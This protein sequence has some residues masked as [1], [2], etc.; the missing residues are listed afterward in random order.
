MLVQRACCCTAVIER[1]GGGEGG[2]V[3]IGDACAR[4]CAFSYKRAR[5]CACVFVLVYARAHFH[6]AREER[7]PTGDDVISILILSCK[8]A[9]G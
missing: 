1:P 7:D 9:V 5:L 2:G 3:C 6:L 8:V 4:A